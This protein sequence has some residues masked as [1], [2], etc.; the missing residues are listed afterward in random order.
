MSVAAQSPRVSFCDPPPPTC[1]PLRFIAGILAFLMSAL[2]LWMWWDISKYPC[3][4]AFYDG[5]DSPVLAAELASN[6]SDLAKVIAPPCDAELGGVP[7]EDQVKERSAL[8]SAARSVLWRNTFQDCFFIPLYTSFVWVLGALFASGKANWDRALRYLLGV[9]MIAT[10]VADYLENW[11]IFRGL[12][13]GPS[14]W[15]AQQTSRPSRWKW[16]MLGVALLLT[17]VILRHSAN[18]IYSLATR[19]LFALGY[20]ASGG[21]ILVGRWRPTLIELAMKLFEVIVVFHIFA[22]L[23]PC[24]PGRSKKPAGAPKAVSMPAKLSEG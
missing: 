20:L 6:G 23:G 18:P 11:G 8:Q 24:W 12:N 22:L 2:G 4:H 10:G 9:L 16:A 14:D 21:I 19:R 5:I 1:A 13:L 15:I 7:A 3:E 17:F